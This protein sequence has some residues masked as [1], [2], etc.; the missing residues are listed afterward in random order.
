[1]PAEGHLLFVANVDTRSLI[2]H[3]LVNGITVYLNS[4]KRRSF[5]GKI[6]P[7]VFPGTNTI[8]LFLGVAPP[9]TEAPKL[10]MTVQRGVQ[11]AD[12]GEE[13]ELLRFD[14]ST[15]R[16]LGATPTEVFRG[17][18]EVRDISWRPRWISLAPVAASTAEL[19]NFVSDFVHSL[20][21][22]GMDRLVAL[23]TLKFQEAADSLGFDI[24]ELTASFREFLRGLMDDPEWR[25][26][27]VD[28]ERLSYTPEAEGRMVRISQSS[29]EPPIVTQNAAGLI[30][31]EFTVVRVDGQLQIIL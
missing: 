22:R 1:M 29:G 19:Q 17:T 15:Q 27:P 13:G 26:L 9:T 8:S 6:N 30:P 31:F 5:G 21:T 28:I 4:G 25:V 7:L 23:H 12:P 18:F 14:W 20:Q 2:V 10:R 3:V 24:A 11:G 16:P